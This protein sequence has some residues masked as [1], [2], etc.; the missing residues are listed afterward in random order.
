MKLIEKLKEHFHRVLTEEKSAHAIALGF[1][2]GTFI[3]I[4]SPIPGLDFILAL[5]VISIFENL[6]KFSLLAAIVLLNSFITWPIYGVAYKLGNIIFG[7]TEIVRYNI[8]ILNNVYNFSRKF[9]F[10]VLIM[11]ILSSLIM[12]GLVFVFAKLY[13]R[14]KNPKHLKDN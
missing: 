9:A 8:E 14:K 1:A 4:I 13:K 12:Y 3:E 10:G 5:I 2:L 11:S 6:N 7:T